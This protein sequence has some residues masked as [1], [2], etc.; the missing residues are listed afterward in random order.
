MGGMVSRRIADVVASLLAEEPVVALH[1]PR[2][3]GKTTLLRAVAAS[4]GVRVIDLDD[5]ATREAVSA[6][7]ATFVS[8]PQPVCIDE[9]QHVPVV[10][11]AIK[12][13]LNR[14]GSPGRFIITGSTRHDALP[15]AAQALTGRL[16]LVTVYPFSQGEI[17]G[18]HEDTIERLFEDA[19]T[20]VSSRPSQTTREECIGRV[21]TG[22]FP[23][24]VGRSDTAR[25]RWFDNYVALSLER[26]VAEL[27]KVRQKQALPG[28]LNRLAGQTAQVLNMAA[29]G[30]G[31]GLRP[32]TAENYTKLL[33]AIFLV[34]RLPAWGKSLRA[35]A[36]AT[37]K[38]HVVDSGLAARLLRLSARKLARRDSTS[39]QQ[40]GHLL[41]TFVVGEVLKQVSWMTGVSGCGHWRTHDGPEVDVVVERDDGRIV[42]L[43]VKSGTRVRGKDFA[44]LRI[45]R[46][47]LGEAFVAQ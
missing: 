44:G 2:A 37:P 4:E 41:E 33:E 20:L 5:L 36:V 39:L 34:H 42:A 24:A 14:D 46:D 29:A 23:M 12:A 15:A 31:V 7:P 43:E 16:H 28:L 32:D 47:E 30:E 13:E 9:Y 8:G 25:N 3:V 1:G 19:S 35:R 11:D 27:S 17:S 26:D 21:T 45:L 40:F 10:L 38:L 6:D 18:L 22:G